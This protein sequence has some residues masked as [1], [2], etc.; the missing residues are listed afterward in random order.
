MNTF[1]ISPFRLE[2]DVW[3]ILDQTRL[4]GTEVYLRPET[5]EDIWHA[6]NTL[7]VRG[8]PAIGIA[9][10][11]GLWLS[12]KDFTGN[13]EEFA[14]TLQAAKDYLVTARPTAVNLAWALERMWNTW[15][16]SQPCDIITSKDLL[17][18][19]AK[20]IYEED[21]AACK[22]MGDGS[23]LPTREQ[24]RLIVMNTASIQ[25]LPTTVA[26]LRS[27]LGAQAP[28]DILPAVL[29]T[30][31]VSVCAGLSACLLLERRDSHGR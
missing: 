20:K 27:S 16:K 8:A 6:I 22:A 21:V 31:L 11:Y 19:E 7:Q 3:L 30:S 23:G 14:K 5:K 28:L 29:L 18:A 10:A 1:E 25:L 12:V 24:C 4:P 9:A 13:M 17:F 26:A 15:R 2:G